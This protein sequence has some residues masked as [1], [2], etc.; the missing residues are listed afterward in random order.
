MRILLSRTD[1]VGD[2]VLSTPAIATVR[3]SFPDAH[4]TMVCSAYNSV[5]MERNT[6][7]DV[8]VPIPSNGTA[9]ALGASYVGKIDL[10]IALAPRREDF[11]LLRATRAP[12][13]I[14]YT[15]VRRYLSR[16][17][18]PFYLTDL[19]ISEADPELSE[20]DPAR[21]VLHEVDQLL[22]LVASAGARSRSTALRIDVVDADRE[23][24]AY[25]PP[26]PIVVHLGLRWF[27]TGSTFQ[28]T[29]ALIADL[30]TFG[31]PIVVTYGLECQDQAA[32]IADSGLADAVVGGLSFHRWAAAF[33]RA[34]CV[35]TVDTGAT[36]VASAMR[37]PTVVAFEH[38]YFRLSSQ[39]WAP[40]GVPYGVVRKPADENETSLA[41]LRRDIIS[42]V[43]PLIHEHT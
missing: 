41:A 7:V 10:A 36:H 2:L 11:S 6:D 34:R 43:A 3:K 24:V 38:R 9:A 33:E 40:Y 23:A 35:I 30:R 37:R 26:S 31:A 14:G 25:L 32:A 12:R 17:S 16:L 18:A 39:E 13:R 20:R 1:R 4:I 8:T 15:Y 27:G 42:A 5:V 19:S 22:A 21:I 29:L 28:N